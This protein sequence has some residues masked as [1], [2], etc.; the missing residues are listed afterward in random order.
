MIDSSQHILNCSSR[1]ATDWGH[2]PHEY[3]P[4]ISDAI[5]SL[6]SSNPIPIRHLGLTRLST[7][8]FYWTNFLK[9]I[10]STTTMGTCPKYDGWN[11]TTFVASRHAYI[12]NTVA[13]G[14]IVGGKHSICVKINIFPVCTCMVFASGTYGITTDSTICKFIGENLAQNKLIYSSSLVTQFPPQRAV[15]GNWL[16][17]GLYLVQEIKPWLAIDLGK[18]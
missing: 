10:T 4:D 9:D 13:N 18:K 5:N 16:S 15:N 8:S 1:C 7:P 17:G 14:H 2:I 3:S 6:F 11:T 12:N